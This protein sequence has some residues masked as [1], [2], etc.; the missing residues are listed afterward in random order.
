MSSDLLALLSAFGGAVTSAVI[1]EIQT[2]V[3]DHRAASRL[4]RTD[5]SE[6]IA[7][8]ER[9]VARMEGAESVRHD[10]AEGR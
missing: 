7:Q 4:R 5:V 6:R 8:L 3:S 10:A 9:E 2:M 1:R